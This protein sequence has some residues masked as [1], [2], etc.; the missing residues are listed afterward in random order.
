MKRFWTKVDK[1]G[2]PDACWPWL[3][4]SE[5]DGR[6]IFTVAGYCCKAPRVAWQL[7]YGEPPPNEL[8]VCHHCD[9]PNC[10]NPAHLFLGTRMD[11][12]RDAHQKQRYRKGPVIYT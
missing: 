7:A 9:N 10:V 2:G 11:N 3:A 4:A 1:S 6:G 8:L 12:V 5:Y